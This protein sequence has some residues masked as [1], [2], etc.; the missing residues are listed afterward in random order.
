MVQLESLG[1]WP[2]GT[3]G[4][5]GPGPGLYGI[6]GPEASLATLDHCQAL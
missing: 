3:L 2:R 5:S 6:P 1:V 4:A